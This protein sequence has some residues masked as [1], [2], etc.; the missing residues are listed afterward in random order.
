MRRLLPP[1]WAPGITMIK[2]AEMRGGLCIQSSFPSPQK[3]AQP[4]FP[5]DRADEGLSVAQ[6]LYPADAWG[7]FSSLFLF[8]P[9]L[10]V[11]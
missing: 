7:P 5:K 11:Y 4:V 6:F 10:F 3:R 8:P 1:D 9:S 2:P